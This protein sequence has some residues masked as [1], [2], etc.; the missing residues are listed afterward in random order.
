MP[1]PRYV[2]TT[3]TKTNI[4]PEGRTRLE[5]NTDGANPKRL[6][7]GASTLRQVAA[8][9]VRCPVQGTW[10]S[11]LLNLEGDPGWMPAAGR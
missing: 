3:I 6:T 2:A 8:I 1:V 11:P 7:L 10:P 5:A 4:Q 9:T